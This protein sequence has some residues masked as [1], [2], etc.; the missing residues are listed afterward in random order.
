MTPPE[1][2]AHVLR[3]IGDAKGRLGGLGRASVSTK[4]FRPNSKIAL[5]PME[6]GA[7]QSKH[8]L[9]LRGGRNQKRKHFFYGFDGFRAP[10]SGF[11]TRGGCAHPAQRLPQLWPRFGSVRAVKQSTAADR[12]FLDGN[13]SVAPSRCRIKKNRFARS[14]AI[15][16]IGLS[17]C[18]GLVGGGRT[19]RTVDALVAATHWSAV[20]PRCPLHARACQVWGLGCR[21]RPPFEVAHV[22]MVRPEYDFFSGSA[23]TPPLVVL[24][25]YVG[26]SPKRVHRRPIAL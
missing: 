6:V 12:G 11:S 14:L 23:E 26:T 15:K 25:K 22:F 24:R 17:Q 9:R 2:V 8:R 16:V 10:L 19:G 1:D 4:D 3:P 7:L 20:K 13:Q 18:I 21:H 5:E